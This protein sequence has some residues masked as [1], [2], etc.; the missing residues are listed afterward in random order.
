MHIIELAK[1]LRVNARQLDKL[2]FSRDLTDYGIVPDEIAGT[3]IYLRD[4]YESKMVEPVKWDMIPL[5]IRDLPV[6]YF[7]YDGPAITYVGKSFQI[8]GRMQGHKPK[9]YDGFFATPVS[10]KDIDIMEL[11]YI[12]HYLP[13][14]NVSG[15]DVMETIRQIIKQV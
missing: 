15:K 9:S 6:I 5:S 10:R 3:L 4:S 13:R 11:L 8:F 7:L 2:L 12:N 14:D 1:Q